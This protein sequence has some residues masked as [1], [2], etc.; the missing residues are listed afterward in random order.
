M[1]EKRYVPRDPR[2]Q[3]RELLAADTRHQ[4]ISN[5]KAVEETESLYPWGELQEAGWLIIDREG[6]VQSSMF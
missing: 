4:A 2:G 3:S 1:S 6:P 5:V